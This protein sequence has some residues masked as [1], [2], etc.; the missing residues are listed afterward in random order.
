MNTSTATFLKSAPD[1]AAC[2]DDDQPEF[3]FA[4]RSNV[5]KSSLLNLLVG[6]RDLARV[7]ATPGHTRHLNFFDINGRW[8]L[9]DMP[10]YGY[11]KVA[12]SEKTNFT[13]S[14][15]AYLVERPN[16]R[17][18]FTLID[19]SIPPQDIDL[20]FVEFL[21]DNAVPFVLVFTKIDKA[22]PRL[23]EET[24]ARFRTSLAEWTDTPPL[25]LTSS[26]HRHRGRNAL[27]KVI[28]QALEPEQRRPQPARKPAKRTTPW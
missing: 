25:I 12:K 21:I 23:T 27:L 8:R 26:A 9:V 11:A 22:G 7:S 28:E 19:A 6:R 24:M 20:E 3:A 14:V 13:A 1:L 2:P 5:G 16:L 4:G 10:G 18:V 15:A 17:C